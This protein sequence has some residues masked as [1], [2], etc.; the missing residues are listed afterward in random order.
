MAEAVRALL[1][2]ALILPTVP[3]VRAQ[4]DDQA[5]PIQ[6]SLAGL[7]LGGSLRSVRRIYPPALEWPSTVEKRAGVTRYR[8][9]RAA[10]KAFPARVETLYLGFKKG[11]L[12]EIEAVYDEEKSRAQTVEK[13]AGEYALA[14]GEAK[15]AGESFRWSDAKTVLRIFPAETPIAADGKNA[16]AWRSAVQIFDRS[17][18]ARDE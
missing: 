16:V 7:H 2:A 4:D 8:V 3:A 6:R 5:T 10:A 9:E 14:Y 1:L 17:L 11:S 13:L 15:R 12:V 18:A